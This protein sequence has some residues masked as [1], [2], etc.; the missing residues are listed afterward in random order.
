MD[1]IE[2]PH[3]L[4]REIERASRLASDVTDQTTYQWLKR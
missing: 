1:Q 4:E 2:D 3:D